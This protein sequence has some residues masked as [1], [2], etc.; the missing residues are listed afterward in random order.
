M[1]LCYFGDSR[2]TLP[3]AAMEF[4]AM[5]TFCISCFQLELQ[6]LSSGCSP[7]HARIFLVA[8]IP[9]CRSGDAVDGDALAYCTVK[10][11]VTPSGK[12]WKTPLK[13]S[14]LS[15]PDS[16]DLKR[17]KSKSNDTGSLI[18]S[19]LLMAGESS[20]H[21]NFFTESINKF[22]LFKWEGVHL[23]GT[24]LEAGMCKS[25]QRRE[26]TGLLFSF[27]VK[28]QRQMCYSLHETTFPTDMP[29]LQCGR[30][31]LSFVCFGT[32]GN[33]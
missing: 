31:F 16:L 22:I 1:A 27:K 10:T 25:L 26:K 19:G 14:R 18:C 2:R 9:M 32:Y 13:V 6:K 5:R 17:S 20:S 15:I 3:G 28:T 33:H 11:A 7:G 29:F 12:S 24:V 8:A 4:K 30:G 21:C 23:H